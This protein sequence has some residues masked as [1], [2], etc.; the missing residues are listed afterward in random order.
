VLG[1]GAGEWGG[2]HNGIVRIGVLTA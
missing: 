1:A 2:V